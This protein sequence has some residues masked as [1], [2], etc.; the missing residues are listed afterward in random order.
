MIPCRITSCARYLPEKCVSNDDLEQFPENARKLIA[1]KTGINQR[2]F[3]APGQN[4]SDL[5]LGAAR[6]CL[7]QS[8]TAP[9]E[10]DAIILATSSPDFILPATAARLQGMLEAVNAFALDINAVCSGAL[11]AIHLGQSLIKSGNARKVLV[12]AAEL[13]SRFLNP[14]DF[15]TFPYFG[16]GAGAILLES[17]QGEDCFIAAKLQTDGKGFETIIIPGGGSVAPAPMLTDPEDAYFHMQG[18]E[19]F[20]FAVEKGSRSIQHVLKAARLEPSEID[21]FVVHQANVNILKRIAEQCGISM[22]KFPIVLDRYGNTAG[23]SVL[24]TL[25]EIYSTGEVGK[26]IALTAMGGGLSWGTMVV[27]I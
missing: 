13:Y 16:D 15:S 5:A 12:V 27:R 3:A 14:K 21:H 8:G 1:I 4:T 19:V 2:R 26:T 10:L 7:E 11:Y 20:E 18:K 22:D 6:K 24:I 23:A 9:E 17:S 25:S